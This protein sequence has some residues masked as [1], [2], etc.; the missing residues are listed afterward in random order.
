MP[1]GT[2]SVRSV[3]RHVMDSGGRSG[4]GSSTTSKR[5]SRIGRWCTGDA[6]GKMPRRR[7]GSR[8]KGKEGREE[9]VLEGLMIDSERVRSMRVDCLSPP[10]Y[11]PRPDFHPD[12]NRSI[13]YCRSIGAYSGAPTS[14]GANRPRRSCVSYSLSGSNR[15]QSRTDAS[16]NPNGPA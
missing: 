9:S 6:N 13:F 10:S 4:I 11:L 14:G 15:G 12:V 8:G 7:K 16:T 5:R 1:R 3:M 2:M